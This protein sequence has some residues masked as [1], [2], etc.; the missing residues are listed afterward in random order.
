MLV[1]ERIGSGSETL[2][3]YH[4]LIK[5]RQWIQG[6]LIHPLETSEKKAPENRLLQVRSTEPQGKRLMSI[7]GSYCMLFQSIY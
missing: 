2:V 5:K 6:D 4:A 1:R 3:G 7:T